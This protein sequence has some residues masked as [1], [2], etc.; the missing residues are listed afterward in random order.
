MSKEQENIFHKMTD[1]KKLHLIWDAHTGTCYLMV[2][3][4]NIHK[5]SLSK[6][7][8]EKKSHYKG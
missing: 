1:I 6:A 5:E 8:K 7:E 2:K 3:T 4:L